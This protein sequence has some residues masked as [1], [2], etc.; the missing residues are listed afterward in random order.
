MPRN[1][2]A[3]LPLYLLALGTVGACSS[4]DGDADPDGGAATGGTPTGGSAGTGGSTG[5]SAGGADDAGPVGDA[6]NPD[7]P[8]WQA[9][10]L[11]SL[12][13]VH[14]IVAVHAGETPI[15]VLAA[16][17]GLFRME[18]GAI[19]PVQAPAAAGGY[20]AVDFAPERG[21]YA[22]SA[23]GAI[24]AMGSAAGP[25][26]QT[27]LDSPAPPEELVASNTGFVGLR[28]ANALTVFE[29]LDGIG[30]LGVATRADVFM[31]VLPE[32]PR[33]LAARVDELVSIDAVGGEPV[34]LP[35]G[36]PLDG[37]NVL[38][39]G[40]ASHV[41][42]GDAAGR[43]V[44]RVDG[45]W[46]RSEGPAAGALRGADAGPAGGV[47]VGDRG[48]VLRQS[49]ETWVPLEFPRADDLVDVAAT[50]G[51]PVLLTASGDVL[52]FGRASATPT[53]GSAPPDV[54][55]AGM[56]DA[57]PPPPAAPQMR[58]VSLVD[59]TAVDACLDGRPFGGPYDRIGN[60]GGAL[61]SGYQRLS[62]GPHEI[63]TDLY[64]NPAQRCQTLIDETRFT[65][66]SDELLMSLHWELIGFQT[67]EIVTDRRP[68]TDG[69]TRVRAF[70]RSVS[71]RVRLQ[72]C[73]DGEPL[74][75]SFG[76]IDRPS[77]T[78]EVRQLADEHC[79]GELV[80]TAAIDLTPGAAS[81]VV[82]FS[83]GE[84]DDAGHAITVCVDVEA[85]GAL[86]SGD[87]CRDVGLTAP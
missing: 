74:P 77:F 18:A 68:P 3:R 13:R 82:A 6:A 71:R 61:S 30:I 33:H 31:A 26:A 35:D 85:D 66:R 59:G 46:R 7:A 38:R 39:M 86:A 76:A 60:Q 55:D 47:L 19:Y 23:D 52:W 48:R 45:V 29:H 80:G 11:A 57:G 69:T 67:A 20:A 79:Q 53:F 84:R 81:T 43:I 44:E 1:R 10:D 62:D 24:W 36:T 27:N 78:A 12:G 17:Q 41:F 54:P 8:R 28:S 72:V 14:D 40:P 75:A 5:G 58:V 63:D 70:G 73:I 16:E 4:S 32:G 56:P 22:V 21:L 2:L 64:F 87:T 50:P 37:V 51:E 25:L 15:V 42:G 34:R 83:L 9:L 65:A 49:A